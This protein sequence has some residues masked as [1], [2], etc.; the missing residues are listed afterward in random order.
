MPMLLKDL[1]DP[2]NRRNTGEKARLG[3]EYVWDE[4]DFD[5]PWWCNNVTIPNEA[6]CE[7]CAHW[8]DVLSQCVNLSTTRQRH[9][10]RAEDRCNAWRPHPEYLR[11]VECAK[12][13]WV[14]EDTDSSRARWN[15]EKRKKDRI[16][17]RYVKGAR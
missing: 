3:C 13:R 14:P 8:C 4:P 15:R 11:C 12:A 2:R 16:V 6:R 1:S 5:A 7:T 17:R 9:V 10:M